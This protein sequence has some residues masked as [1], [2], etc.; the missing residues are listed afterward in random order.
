MTPDDTRDRLRYLTPATRDAAYDWD[1]STG[2]LWCSETF[3]EF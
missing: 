2:F 3:Q 1:A